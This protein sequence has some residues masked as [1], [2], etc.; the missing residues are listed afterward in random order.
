[1]D[2]PGAINMKRL[3]ISTTMRFKKLT[4]Q[5]FILAVVLSSVY[6]ISRA[7][8][9][10]EYI[11]IAGLTQGTS[12]HITYESKKGENL[13]PF[14]DSLLADYDLSLSA[15]NPNSL[16]SR[17]NRNDPGTRADQ[18]FKDVFN[19]SY[20]VYVKTGGAF[21]IT[22]APIINALGFGSSKDTLKVD[23]T[24]IDSLLAYV[25]MDKVK[26]NGDSLEKQNKNIKI[27]VNGIAQGY[28]VDL[29]AK[30]LE[31]RKIRNYM[32]EIGGEVRARGRN[33]NNRIWRIGIDKPVEG[34]M[35][36]GAELEAII[37][38]D[39]RSL[40]TAGNYRKFY[41]RNGIKYAHIIN[42]K[43]GYPEFSKLL[44][45][46][47]VARDCLTADA[48]DT[49]LMVLGLEKSIQFLKENTFLEAYL[50]YTDEKGDYKVYATPGLKKYFT[51]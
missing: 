28:S 29:V 4:I 26:L 8:K 38:L 16:I 47:V 27:D 32:V 49:P 40:A 50:I 15:Y 17:F 39:N 48:Y 35:M 2:N 13:K 1:M 5:L 9:K 43:T 31:G 44:S 21:D 10:S 25:G 6:L 41:E 22:V 45:A 37:R 42:P 36:P 14:I 23:S 33:Q 11:S 51:E 30:Y 3:N 12:Y 18:K 19:K 46:T 20:E 24:M 7:T 34:N